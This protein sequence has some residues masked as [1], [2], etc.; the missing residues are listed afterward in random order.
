MDFAH[1]L[2]RYR[3]MP[4]VLEGRNFSGRTAL[5]HCCVSHYSQRRDRAIYVGSS[6]HRHLSSLMSNV[7]DELYLHLSGAPHQA[8]L[9]SLADV[10]GL[11]R[12]FHR[13]PFTLSGGEQALLV[14]ICK[15]GL[16]PSLVAFDC[17]LG[18][19][20][21]DNTVRVAQV[22][23]APMVENITILITE[24]GYR[25]DHPWCL[26]IRR[27]VSEFMNPTEMIQPPRFHASDL[28]ARPSEDTGPLEA[29]RLCFAYEKRMPI[30]RG[31]SFCLNP[32]RIYSLEG[33]N[34]AGK[35]TLARILV[36]ALPLQ[37]GQIYFAGRNVKPWKNPAQ[38]VA[39]H[40]Q[41][42]D[43]QLF[44]DSIAEEMSD[45]S[46]FLRKSAA[47]LAGVE[48]LMSKHPFDLPFVLRK[49]LTFS[50]VAHLRR[51]WFIFDEPT[52]GQDDYACDQMV[53]VLRSLT[54]SGAGIIVVSHSR[55][56]I[57]RLQAQRLWL[58]N[59]LINVLEHFSF[60]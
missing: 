43:V 58:E 1:L 48:G 49:R 46:P 29:E 56:F 7:R 53:A 12:H 44:G 34:G 3:N 52:L 38:I 10:F 17:A 33:R 30:L 14:T 35:S 39:M 16:A 26:P 54:K 28:R 19:L 32:G 6:I 42:P 31:A 4:V 8:W 55:E 11:T 41:D 25:V 47:A 45:L 59:G 22:F 2:E 40:A 60:K 23:S 27:P 9:L 50:I 24:N 36:G 5:L 21:A 18:E 15:L 13:S 20:D 57:R 51:P 37:G